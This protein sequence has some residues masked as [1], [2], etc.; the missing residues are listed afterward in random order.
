MVGRKIKELRKSLGLNQT[1]FAKPLFVT[2]GSVSQWELGLTM[3]DT[4][5][6]ITMSKVYGVPLG[7]FIDEPNT[8]ASVKEES[9]PS[10]SS[11][12]EKL[13]NMLM[14]L[15]PDQVQLVMAFVSGLRASQS[16]A[17]SPHPSA[18]EPRP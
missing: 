3:P 14:D 13:V 16:P 12:D 7:Y 5:R 10:G 11:L 6:L 15:P 8:E 18:S 9:S 17:F 1:Q 4:D 2:A